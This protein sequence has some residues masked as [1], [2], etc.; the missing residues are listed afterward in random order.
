MTI[1]LLPVSLWVFWTSFCGA[2]Q[3]DTA[4]E[5]FACSHQCTW[6]V[7]RLSTC[8]AV[9][10]LSPSAFRAAR[11]APTASGLLPPSS[12][13][14]KRVYRVSTAHPL[15]KPQPLPA[16]CPLEHAGCLVSPPKFSFQPLQCQS[17]RARPP[18]WLA[19][20]GTRLGVI[21]HCQTCF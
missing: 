12:A 10:V 15:Q 17:G 8:M 14:C 7:L 19:L 1:R 4:P 9:L 21:E 13:A 18:F 5:S 16:V 6:S 11:V 3:R 20:P 2:A